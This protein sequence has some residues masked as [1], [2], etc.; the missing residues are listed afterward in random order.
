MSAPKLDGLVGVA[1]DV[2]EALGEIG[3]GL[4]V[5]V[6]NLFP[7]IPSEVV[8]PLA[9]FLASQGRM[10]LGLVILAATLGSLLGAI[11]LYELGARVPLVQLR[12]ILDRLPLMEAA[13]LDAAELWFLRHGTASVLLGRCVPL[14]RSL[15]SIPA[16]V[17][18]M[19]RWRFTLLTLAG[20]LVWNS[21]FVVAGFLLAERFAEV[22]GFS[23][24]LNRGVYFALLVALLLALRRLLRRRGE[25]SAAS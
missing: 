5:A 19:P 14:V 17:A 13:D 2:M 22:E 15:V 18:R 23:V 11:V 10:E 6:E 21:V 8:L 7:P 16:G 20:S 25:G 12:R 24:W 3:V 1:A 4:V 9:G